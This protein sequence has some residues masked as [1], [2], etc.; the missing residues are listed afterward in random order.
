VVLEDLESCVPEIP[1]QAFMDFLVPPQPDFN[2][3]AM[4]EMLKSDS[5]GILTASGRWTAYEEEPKDQV[6]KEDAIF[7]P[8]SD[9]FKKTGDAIIT[10]SNLNLTA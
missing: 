6:G 8:M 10:N 9:I 2:I 3:E 7:K 4:M 1:L 5:E